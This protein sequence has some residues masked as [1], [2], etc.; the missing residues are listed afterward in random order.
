ML[1]IKYE[2]GRYVVDATIHTQI[3]T[4]DIAKVQEHFMVDCASEFAEAIR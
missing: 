4:L 3:S 1:N 2:N